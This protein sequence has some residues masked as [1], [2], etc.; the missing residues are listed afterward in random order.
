MIPVDDPRLRRYR[1]L[2]LALIGNHINTLSISKKILSDPFSAKRLLRQF[3]NRAGEGRYL[4]WPGNW[5]AAEPLTIGDIGVFAATW[6]NRT[7]GDGIIHHFRRVGNII[8]EVGE[9]EVKDFDNGSHSAE[10]LQAPEVAPYVW[11]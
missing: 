8:T 11:R 5:S 3:W 1:P 4:Q 2:A 7:T 9:F 10:R 6:E